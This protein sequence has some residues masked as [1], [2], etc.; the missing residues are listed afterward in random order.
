MSQASP[1][2]LSFG[3]QGDKDEKWDDVEEE[4]NDDDEEEE[5]EIDR[6]DLICDVCFK[7]GLPYKVASTHI[8][9]TPSCPSL[10]P[11]MIKYWKEHPEEARKMEF[12]VDMMMIENKYKMEKKIARGEK[13]ARARR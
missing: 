1:N 5:D 3:A 13:V 2:L 9:R 10:T 8:A 6:L 4:G 12:Q 7:G 11:E